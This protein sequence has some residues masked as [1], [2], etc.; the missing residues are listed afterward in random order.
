MRPGPATRAACSWFPV[1]PFSPQGGGMMLLGPT[2]L[3]RSAAFAKASCPCRDLAITSRQPLRWPAA[4]SCSQ[5]RRASSKNGGGGRNARATSPRSRAY[6][7]CPP[8]IHPRESPAAAGSAAIILTSQE[9]S[10]FA[11]PTLIQFV[12][13]RNTNSPPPCA[14]TVDDG[15]SLWKTEE[16]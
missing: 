10:R 3:E 15:T 13:G 16:N 7:E 1:L 5:L 12:A 9:L 8:A 14:E 4:L 11:E 2:A 6:L